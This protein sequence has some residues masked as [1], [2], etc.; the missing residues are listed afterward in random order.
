MHGMEP[1]ISVEENVVG[2]YTEESRD[3]LSVL[4]LPE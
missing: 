4:V 3:V 2:R 1:E